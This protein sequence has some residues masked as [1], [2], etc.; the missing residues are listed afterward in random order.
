MRTDE[1]DRALAA[2]LRRLGQDVA[3]TGDDDELVAQV[4]AGLQ[5]E[6]APRRPART[7]GHRQR[8]GD[9][10]RAR[11]RAVVAAL[12]ALLVG[13]AITPPVRAAV[14]EWFGFGGVIVREAPHPGPRT[15]PPPPSATSDL[16]LRQAGEL[17]TFTP[18]A[19]S[20]LGTPDGVEVSGDRRVL[21][22]TWSDNGRMVRLDQF[23]GT[24][25]PVM[26]K[27][28]HDVGIFT[29]AGIEYLWVE[30]PHEVV[31]VDPDGTERSESAR[32][33]GSTLI[34]ERAGTTLRL[35]ADV[36]RERAVVIARSLK[37]AG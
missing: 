8:A 18:V 26:A 34:W 24:L 3:V 14:A 20:A 4:M 7:A 15:A 5:A 9:W 16:T 29:V 27:L 33:A 17:V 10:L 35:E 23:D 13:L 28:A 37:L 12:A 19:P 30:R 22:L 21:S 36:T 31:V 1:R 25:S 6:P 11:R 2:E 32:L